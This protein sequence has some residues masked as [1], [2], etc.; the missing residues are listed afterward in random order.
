MD[1]VFG[2]PS[3]LAE[4]AAAVERWTARV[5]SRLAEGAA[6]EPPAFDQPGR[7]TVV[8]AKFEPPV[9]APIVIR[10]PLPL[11]EP[12]EGPAIDMEQLNVASMGV[13]ALRASML[14]AFVADVFP[15]LQAFE[16]GVESGNAEAVE[17]EAGRLRRMCTT[18]GAGG[19]A[20]LFGVAEEWARGGRID[21]VA[22]LLPLIVHEVRRCEEFVS[23]LERMADRDAA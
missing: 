5:E 21:Q 23:R 1:E 14:T 12:S 2:R 18:V 15:R 6:D 10:E 7:L 17:A 13:P 11:P 3:D 4:L 20:R 22:R 19:C 16:D 8:S 9:P